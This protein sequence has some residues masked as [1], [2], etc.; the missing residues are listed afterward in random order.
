VQLKRRRHRRK[1]RESITAL[2]ASLLA[3]TIS[4]PAKAQDGGSADSFGP[5]VNYTQFDSA[6]LVYQES[7]SRVLAVE[8]AATLTL[9]GSTGAQLGLEIV[10]DAV[11]GATPNGAVPS[12]LSQNFVTPVR[13]VT[14][15]SSG[16]STTV[17]GSSGGST[18]ITLPGTPGSVSYGT[19]TYTV[20]PNMLPVDK[21][22]NDRREGVNLS[23]SQPLAA[24]SDFGF[25]AGYSTEKD[26]RA[27]TGNVHVSENLNTDNTTLSLALNAEFDTSSPYGGVPTPFTPMSGDWKKPAGKDKTQLG[28]VLG[29]TEVVSRHWLMQLNY[30]LDTQSG[31]QNDP[32]RILSVVDSVTGQPN[33]YLYENRPNHR[34]SQSIYWDN[35]FD[36]GPS[37]TDLSFRYFTDDWG[38]NSKTAE[39]SERIDLSRSWYIE[40]S[41]RWYQQSSASFFRSYLVQ[42]QALPT[43][44][45]SDSRLEA[46]SSL[47]FGAK[48]G[49][50]LTGRTELYFR[51][52]YYQQQGNGHPV[53]A[54]GQ[55]AN[56][57][58]FSGTNAAFGFIGYTWDFH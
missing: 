34:L 41:V 2:S 53:G 37:V 49:V 27:I 17:T 23:W 56:Q 24:L 52:G 32:Y 5:G 46:F 31:Y 47:T 44:A 8:P 4:A 7:G 18:V 11:S 1:V 51:G 15:G 6:L 54:I 26:Y 25:G 29:L 10:F 21:G 36:F 12:T 58:L 45:S 19:R 9:H 55:L 42:G 33:A 40:P 35:R 20:A 16:G 28:F 48:L 30:S 39:L 22:F 3:A 43:F 13:I 38:I 14:P 57:S 50:N